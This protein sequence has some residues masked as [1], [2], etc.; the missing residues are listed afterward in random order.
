MPYKINNRCVEINLSNAI[1][2]IQCQIKVV[3]KYKYCQYDHLFLSIGQLFYWLIQQINFSSKIS[4]I[5]IKKKV[6]FNGSIGK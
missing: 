5:T 1:I 4:S 2:I 6:C 3:K